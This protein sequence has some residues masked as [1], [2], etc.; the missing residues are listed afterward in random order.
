MVNDSE[1]IRDFVNTLHKDPQL[2]EDEEE[3]ATPGELDAWLR[4]HGLPVGPKATTAELARAR[5]LREALR[6]LLLAN[7]GEDVDVAPANVALDA[8]ACRA[9]VE[10]RFE[11][12]GPALVPAAPGVAGALGRIAVAVQA[13]V[14]DGSWHRLKACRARDCEWAFIDNA[15]NQSR[16]WCSMSSCGNRE[17]ARV[18]RAR[19]R[20]AGA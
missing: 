2:D 7:N 20:A 8:A 14:A 4:A 6:T 16:A 3:L 13:A 12:A 19:H 9:R 10:L 1:L 11:D 5:E 18:H 15:K 17:K